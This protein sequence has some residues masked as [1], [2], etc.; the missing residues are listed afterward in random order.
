M[1]MGILRVKTALAEA[2][3]IFPLG[4]LIASALQ[5]AKKKGV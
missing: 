4:K 1:G 5:M 3:S 2:T